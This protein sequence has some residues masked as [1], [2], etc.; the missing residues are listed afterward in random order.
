MHFFQRGVAKNS[1][2]ADE[3]DFAVV[4]GFHH[5]KTIVYVPGSAVVVC[6]QGHVG[7]DNEFYRH[8]EPTERACV[9]RHATTGISALQA[10]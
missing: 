4:D 8:V 1:G 10:R 6:A 3:V 9:E 2:H 7:I 5:R